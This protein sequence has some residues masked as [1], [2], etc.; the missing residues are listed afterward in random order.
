[1]T[2]SRLLDLI[3]RG[4]TDLLIDLLKLPDWRDALDDGPVKALPWCVYCNDL[5]T[6]RA[7]LAAGG[8]LSSIDLD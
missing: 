3:A 6:L 2:R 5:T 7:V 4:R 8:D 1:M